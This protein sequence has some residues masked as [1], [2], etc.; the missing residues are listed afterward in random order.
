MR[1]CILTESGGRGMNGILGE[2]FRNR[3]TQGSS[4]VMI[5]DITEQSKVA[6]DR[7][8]ASPIQTCVD[9]QSLEYQGEKELL[10]NLHWM[11]HG[12]GTRSILERQTV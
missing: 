1:R 7:D 4:G 3:G 10:A 5:A 12:F 8:Y 6:F 2:G 11:P 9:L